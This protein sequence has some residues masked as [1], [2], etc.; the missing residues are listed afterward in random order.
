[1]HRTARA[2]ALVTALAALVVPLTAAPASAEDERF[3]FKSTDSGGLTPGLVKGTIRWRSASRAVVVGAVKDLC[4]GDG[5]AAFGVVRSYD[6]S[7][8]EVFEVARTSGPCGDDSTVRFRKRFDNGTEPVRIVV[9]DICLRDGQAAPTNCRS[10]TF[11]NP[12]VV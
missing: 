10:R 1:M 6:A 4:P 11:Q 2:A 9:V 3:R 12:F 5:R 7:A 8:R